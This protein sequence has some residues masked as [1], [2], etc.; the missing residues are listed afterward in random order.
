MAPSTKTKLGV[1]LLTTW[2]LRETTYTTTW[3]PETPTKLMAQVF[4]G[5]LPPLAREGKVHAP[6]SP[7]PIQTPHWYTTCIL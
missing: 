3:A 2:I 5:G 4:A 6:G 1:Q 7:H